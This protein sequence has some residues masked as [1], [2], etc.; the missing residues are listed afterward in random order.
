MYITTYGKKF[1][2]N[3]LDEIHHNI[4]DD[5]FINFTDASLEFAFKSY[6]KETQDE[7]YKA[8][9]E[10]YTKRIRLKLFLR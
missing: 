6:Y 8:L 3:S 7:E 4:N 5:S 2:Y 10:M 9:Y 1:I